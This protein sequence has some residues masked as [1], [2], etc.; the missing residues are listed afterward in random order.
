MEMAV[1]QYKMRRVSM[2]PDAYPANPT[3]KLKCNWIECGPQN[4][5]QQAITAKKKMAEAQE[6]TLPLHTTQGA[7][8]AK[9]AAQHKDMNA[10]TAPKT[11]TAAAT[12]TTSWT[13]NFE[14]RQSW[15]AQDR[16]HEL[17]M[18]AVDDVRAGP[19]FTERSS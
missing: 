4:I 1:L 8:A 10:E 2:E 13:P 12:T 14:R 18:A 17:H 15:S 11:P 3:S 19:G 5:H 9:S 6:M 16:K 7:E